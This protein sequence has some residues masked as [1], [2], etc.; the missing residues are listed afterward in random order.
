MALQAQHVACLFQAGA[1]CIMAIGTTNSA[2]VHL[3]LQ[4]GA[5]NV[6]FFEDLA[7]AKVEFLGQ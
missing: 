7:I 2:V 4:K 5:V 6:D 1:V 3:A